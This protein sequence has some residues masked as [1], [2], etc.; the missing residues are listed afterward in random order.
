MSG[1]EETMGNDNSC[2]RYDDSVRADVVALVK[3]INSLLSLAAKHDNVANEIVQNTLSWSNSKN[4][5]LW[6]KKCVRP[7]AAVKR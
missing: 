6:H 4:S 5:Y 2:R 3:D 7:S 1:L